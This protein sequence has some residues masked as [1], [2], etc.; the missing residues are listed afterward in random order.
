[1]HDK[2]PVGELSIEEL[3]RILAIRKREERQRQLARMKRS[4]RIVGSPNAAQSAPPPGRPPSTTQPNPGAALPAE[5]INL[6]KSA[7][8]TSREMAPRFEDDP[9]DI[10]ASI[11][12]EKDRVWKQFVNRALLLVEITAVIG[13]IFIGW[14]LFG[15][16][17]KLEEETAAAQS[18]ADEVR[19]TGI[20]TIAPTPQLRLE[21]IVL[22][23]GHKP[24]GEFNYDEIPAHLLPVVQAQIQAPVIRRP[25][26]TDETALA[27][28]IPKLGID[29]TIVQGTDE[30]ALKQGVAQLQNG[31]NPGDEAGNV[32]LA[33]HNDIYGELFRHIDQLEVGDQFE[34][35]TATKIHLYRVIGKEIVG[36]DAVYVMDSGSTPTATL[37]SCYPYQVNNKRIVIFA[38]RV[39]A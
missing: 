23:G 6:P 33:A 28:A 9:G 12:A 30:E 27:L 26:P 16:I 20:P 39:G 13:L 19:R 31:I 22:P 34:I 37:I 25:P 10:P 15:A 38:D 7:V 4:G 32:V 24:N 11:A 5:T 17:D 18:A 2:R 36:P 21:Q 1:M 14:N 35:R 8:K 3:E 29:G